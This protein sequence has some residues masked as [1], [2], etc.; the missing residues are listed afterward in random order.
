M[1]KG[2]FRREARWYRVSDVKVCLMIFEEVKG[3][4]DDQMAGDRQLSSTADVDR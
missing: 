2:H 4:T 1:G 3:R